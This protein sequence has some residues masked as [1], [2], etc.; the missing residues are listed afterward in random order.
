MLLGYTI[1]TCD[2]CG[3]T[4]RRAKHRISCDGIEYAD[5]MSQMRQYA[6]HAGDYEWCAKFQTVDIPE[7][8]GEGR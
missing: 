2:D 6:H 5:A 4:F 7:N 8:L 1:F 3:Q